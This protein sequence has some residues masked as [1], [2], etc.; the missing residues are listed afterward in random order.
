MFVSVQEYYDLD[1]QLFRVDYYNDEAGLS[2]G[3]HTVI[4]DFNLETQYT[5]NRR[6]RNCSVT[7]IK[8]ER[9]F[10]A[11]VVDGMARLVSPSNLLLLSN[12]FNYTYEGVSIIRGVDVDSWISYHEFQELANGNITDTLFEIF[13]TRLDW[14]TGTTY[15]SHVS[16]PVLWQVRVSGTYTFVNSTTNTTQSDEFTSTFD[17]FSFSSSEPDLDAFDTSVCV[18][19]GDYY[20]V[21]LTLP[22]EGI[23]VDFSLLSRNVRSSVSSFT[24]V[25]PLQIGN[26]HVR[27]IIISCYNTLHVQKSFY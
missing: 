9:M 27:Q 23:Q 20:T 5:I 24:G 14:S 18:G 11:E 13:F 16:E 15:S 26:I 17:T 7:A 6:L 25:K 4:H 22:V 19:E 3:P 8:P 10:D 21:G 2:E 12:D 1:Y